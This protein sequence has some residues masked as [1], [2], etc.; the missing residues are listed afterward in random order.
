[1]RHGDFRIGAEFRCGGR[2]WRCTDIGTRTIVAIRIDQVQVGGSAPERQNVYAHRT[3]LRRPGFQFIPVTEKELFHHL[4]N[5][6]LN[7]GEVVATAEL[8]AIR[9]SL[10]MARMRKIQRTHAE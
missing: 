1:M 2:L 8:R 5:A 3:Y 7:T 9:E 10:L 6:P 4:A